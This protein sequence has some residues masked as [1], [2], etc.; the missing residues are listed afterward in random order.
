MVSLEP[1]SVRRVVFV[2][3]LL[4]VSC[5]RR[6]ALAPVVS[7]EASTDGSAA[8]AE[9]AAASPDAPGEAAL[10]DSGETDADNDSSDGAVDDGEVS[11]PS[12]GSPVPHP[13]DGW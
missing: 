12:V 1:V 6:A 4:G 2:L 8:S 9:P 13:L 11:E 5:A 3:A 10:D 7:P